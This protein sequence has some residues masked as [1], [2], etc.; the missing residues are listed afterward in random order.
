MQITGIR[1]ETDKFQVFHSHHYFIFGR[2]IGPVN[3]QPFVSVLSKSMS[4]AYAAVILDI[5]AHIFGVCIFGLCASN[6]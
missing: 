5:V 6:I 2:F 1:V 4:Q 3:E